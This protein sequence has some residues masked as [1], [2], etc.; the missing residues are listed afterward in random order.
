MTRVS[1]PVTRPAGQALVIGSAGCR[2][3]PLNTLQELGYGCAEAEDPYA[4]MSELS[5]R[6]LAYRAVILSLHSLYKEELHLIGAT[7]RRFPHVEIWLTD[8]DGRQAAMV[9]SMRLGADGLLAEDGLHRIGVPG[10]PAPVPE[11]PLARSASAV[12]ALGAGLAAAQQHVAPAPPSRH[13]PTT[14][15]PAPASPRQADRHVAP[16]EGAVPPGEEAVL[17]ADELRALLREPAA[18]PPA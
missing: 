14:S 18:P 10:V 5:R 13:F 7:K 8:T 9:E 2:A 6:P 11:M 4:A 12:A 3:A 17:T 16:E 15:A 1:L